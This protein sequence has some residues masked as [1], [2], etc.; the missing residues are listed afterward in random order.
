MM[1]RFLLLPLT[2]LLLSACATGVGDSADVWVAKEYSGGRQCEED[3]APPDTRE[4]LEGKGIRVRETAT[5]PMP[6][7]MAC[8]ICPAYA[9][10][11]FAR[12]HQDDADK[13]K[14]ADFSPAEPPQ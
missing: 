2:L 1:W 7:C 9:A 13:A 11:H 4:L 3:F 12:I 10:R 5:E 6:V 8:G 14:E